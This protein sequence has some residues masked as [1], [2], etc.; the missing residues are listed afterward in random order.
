M[1]ACLMLAV[2]LLLAGCAGQEPYRVVF[3]AGFARDEIFRVQD[4]TC[5]VREMAVYTVNAYNR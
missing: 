2:S 3:H 1:L 4:L 5:S